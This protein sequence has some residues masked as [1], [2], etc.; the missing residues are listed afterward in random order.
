MAEPMTPEISRALAEIANGLDLT[1]QG[2]MDLI[3]MVPA[4][5]A[6]EADLPPNL[7]W[8]L[9]TIR[10]EQGMSAEPI[11][12]SSTRTLTLAGKPLTFSTSVLERPVTACGDMP[13]PDD[14]HGTVEVLPERWS[15]LLVPY[16][17]Q[18]PDGRII[19]APMGMEPKS[20]MLPLP[21]TAQVATADAHDNAVPIGRVDRIWTQDGA[22]WGEGT[23]DLKTAEG[24]DWAGRVGRGM[25]GWGSVDLDAG[26]APLVQSQGKNKVPKRTYKDWTFAGFT[27]VTRPAFDEARIRG[28]GVETGDDND[29]IDAHFNSVI[30]EA[31]E[32]VLADVD[33]S[34]GERLEASFGNCGCGGSAEET[35]QSFPAGGKGKLP[36]ADVDVDWDHA[37]ADK[38][39]R[40]W[41]GLDR[42]E[43]P[44]DAWT[45]Y[46]Q[47]FFWH[48]PDAAGFGDYK[49]PF[50]DIID[51][52]LTA[53]P[54]GVFAA[55]GAMQGAR[56][57]PS[58]PEADT[59]AVMSKISAYY[60]QM[61][62]KA[63]WDSDAMAAAMLVD[64]EV[65]LSD[66]FTGRVTGYDAAEGWLRISCGVGVDTIC[67][68]AD[69]SA[70]SLTAAVA[71]PAPPLAPPDEWFTDPGFNQV[72]PL[73][74][75]DDGRVYGHLAPWQVC[76]TGMP[77]DCTT[78][79][80]SQTGYAHFHVGEVVTASGQRL[81]I[82]KIT[83]GTGH[84][85]PGAGWRAAAA[86]YDNTGSVVAVVRAGQDRF[87][88]WLAGS[89]VP[90]VTPLDVVKLRRSPLSGD[91]RRIGAGL[92]LVAALAV[93]VP[94]FSIPRPRA[95][96][97]GRI[98]AS[99]VAAGALS[100]STAPSVGNSLLASATP[101]DLADIV[102]KAV[103]AA[104]DGYV[105]RRQRAA[106]AASRIAELSMAATECAGGCDCT[107]DDDDDEEDDED[108]ES[109]V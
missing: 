98:Q 71:M 82:G 39:V 104:L 56:R 37:A 21:L 45:K 55:A 14:D 24:R 42:E 1:P 40:A 11:A 78:A 41:A 23:F 69:L 86:H 88:I 16:D 67:D 4:N 84:A 7:R 83:L 99:L 61:K 44:A 73:T 3:D 97:A 72:T 30:P 58:I 62:R 106:A 54:R 48:A 109:M 25:A 36:L 95:G 85:G 29:T 33:D 101:D 68:V 28:L 9:S 22:L 90:E 6:T 27:L 89:L 35:E 10:E 51:G 60:R 49:L 79:P 59:D 52:K 47:A 70:E 53:V 64:Q 91:W 103:E 2:R 100:P 31:V 32:Q 15:G 75:D 8:L 19:K 43:P 34:G 63:P 93:N 38:R 108:D 74:I 20:R 13:H 107:C 50:A 46:A 66:G 94:G 92:E 18:A 77:A 26:A 76:H 5:A 12:A 57:A 65:S 105:A 87:G 81:P 80:K 102:A 96:M 17:T